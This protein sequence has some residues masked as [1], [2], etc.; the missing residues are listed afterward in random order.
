MRDLSCEQ[1]LNSFLRPRLIG[2]QAEG[3]EV[4]HGGTPTLVVAR[5]IVVPLVRNGVLQYAL[6]EF[7]APTEPGDSWTL[8]DKLSQPPPSLSVTSVAPEMPASSHEIYEQ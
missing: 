2:L 1:V 8:R 5:D 6:M 7:V 3:R 4:E